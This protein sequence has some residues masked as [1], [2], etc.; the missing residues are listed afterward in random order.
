MTSF[1]K[2]LY[3]K[4]G[5]ADSRER[6]LEDGVTLVE[7]IVVMVIMSVLA[8]G[9]LG[10]QYMLT[11][12][13]KVA[14]SNYFNVD[15]SNRSVNNIVREI[16]TARLSDNGSFTIVSADDNEFIFYSDIDFDNQAERVRYTLNGTSLE[17]GVIEPVGQP[18]TYP[19]GEEKVKEYSSNIRNTNPVFEYYNGDWPA[20]TS[21]NPLATP[22]S[23]SDIKLVKISVRVNVNVNEPEKD[24]LLESFSQIRMLKDN[25]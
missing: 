4:V 21:T 18:A 23:L 8:L 9:F 20:D 15:E 7:L 10:L 5:R 17:K 13:R 16:R 22:A 2:S 1:H 24:F 25:L 6:S 12:N 11:Q 14:I 19:I 3:K